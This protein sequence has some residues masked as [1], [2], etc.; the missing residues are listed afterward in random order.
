M[1]TLRSLNTRSK[2]SLGFVAA[3]AVMAV[4]SAPADAKCGMKGAKT[5]SKTSTAVAFKVR[6][7]KKGV[8]SK[9]YAC[10]KSRG[11]NL[12]LDDTMQGDTETGFDKIVVAG[13]YAAESTAAVDFGSGD[14]T[15]QVQ[16]FD[17]TKSVKSA[18]VQDLVFDLDSVDSEFKGFGLLRLGPD[19]TVAWIQQQRSP[20]VNLVL[21]GR[22]AAKSPTLLA[23]S[24]AVS[25]KILTLSGSTV[26]WQEGGVTKSGNLP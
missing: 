21:G 12:H 26:S 16:V 9:I 25:T 8:G 19:G 24:S 5:L 13:K 1:H 3:A 14:V 22:L 4:G 17:L 7:K 23:N 18:Q 20:A 10:L 6:S 15:P 2:A 11:V